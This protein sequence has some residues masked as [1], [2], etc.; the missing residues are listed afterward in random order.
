MRHLTFPI[1]DTG[2]RYA[3]PLQ[4]VVPPHTQ[5]DSIY[6]FTRMERRR[7]GLSAALNIV[8]FRLMRFPISSRLTLQ[9]ETINCDK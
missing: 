5:G 2:V 9:P 8:F 3:V 4:H 1:I 6:F 7:S